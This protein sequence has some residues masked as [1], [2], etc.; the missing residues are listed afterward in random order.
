MK[1]SNDISQISAEMLLNYLYP[2]MGDQ[3]IARC[4]GTFYRNYNDDQLSVY[5]ETKE[6][7]LARD[8]FL[9][10]LPE[11]LLS[12]EDELKGGDFAEKFKMLEKRRRLLKEAFLPFDTISFRQRMHI[13]QQI[14]HLLDVKLDY[15]LKTFFHYDRAKETN[16]YVRKI[17][18]LLPYVSKLRADFSGMAKLLGTIMGCRI[19]LKLGRYSQ[20]DS[21]LHWIPSVEYQLL[22]PDLTAEQYD[23]LL[24]DILPLQAFIAEWFTPA[25][26]RCKI[27]IKHH[28][29]PQITGNK[30][31]LNYNTEL[32]LSE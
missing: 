30:L 2:D 24:A 29:Q 11:S 12:S 17:A 28:R 6:V 20:T 14:T 5:E 21:T 3:W 15:M 10:L 4:L 23:K 26:V 31:I 1:V 22:I 9:K 19:K 25:E 7:I 13:E 32:N 16:P 27:S 8:G 18:V